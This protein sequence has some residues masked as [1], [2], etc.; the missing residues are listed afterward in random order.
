MQ[1]EQPGQDSLDA[2]RVDILVSD[3]DRIKMESGVELGR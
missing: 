2:K 3:F 1:I